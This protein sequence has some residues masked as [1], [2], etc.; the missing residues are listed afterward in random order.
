PAA[1]FSDL[2]LGAIELLRGV[3]D[4]ACFSAQVGSDGV[5]AISAQLAVSA[6]GHAVADGDLFRLRPAAGQAVAIE[7]QVKDPA[8][9]HPTVL[10][11]GPPDSRQSTNLRSV[12]TMMA[13]GSDAI[14]CIHLNVTEDAGGVVAYRSADTLQCSIVHEYNSDNIRLTPAAGGETVWIKLTSGSS[15]LGIFPLGDPVPV[16]INVNSHDEGRDAYAY[17]GHDPDCG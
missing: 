4:E 10:V 14:G 12:V 2:S 15:Q 1:A 3:G 16:A 11:G 13:S 9:V 17:Q 7:A 6:C 5:P 8:I